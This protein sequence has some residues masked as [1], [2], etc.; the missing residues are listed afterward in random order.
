MLSIGFGD[1]T[2]LRPLVMFMCDGF[3]LFGPV[4]VFILAHF[5]SRYTH[6]L[7]LR[8]LPQ[9]EYHRT[10]YRVFAAIITI[11]LTIFLGMIGI[12]T[13]ILKLL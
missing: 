9:E 5:L 1:I 4:I 3:A 7:E 13:I 2:L 10:R 6:D 11:L 12:Y 8:V